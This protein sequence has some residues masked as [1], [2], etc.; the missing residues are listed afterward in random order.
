MLNNVA[1]GTSYLP[2]E[3]IINFGPDV[4]LIKSEAVYDLD[5]QV[6]GV[7][8]ALGSARDKAGEVVY[9]AK[10]RAGE[11]AENIGHAARDKQIEF[12][13]GKTVSR[14][15]TDDSGNIIVSVGQVITRSLAERADQ[16][17][18]LGAL[19]AAAGGTMLSTAASRVQQTGENA[20][21]GKRAGRDVEADDGSIIVANGQR[22]REE[23]VE[24]ARSKG[25]LPDLLA[26]AGLGQA[27]Q[28][29][30]G[31]G[32]AFS[33]TG[34][35]AGQ[36][37][38]EAGDTAGDLWD[39]FTRKISQMT[40]SAGKRV[41]EEK[42]KKRLSDIQDAVGRPV[43]KVILDKQDNVVLNLGDIITHE[44][45]Q[46]AYEAGMLDTLL[47]NVYKGDVQFSKEE[48]R[49]TTEGEATIEKSSG[50]AAV[51]QELEQ[52][53]EQAQQEREMESQHKRQEADQKRE[54]RS[55][56]REAL[57]IEREEQASDSGGSSKASGGKKT[58][59]TLAKA[60]TETHTQAI[61]S[62]DQFESGG[63]RS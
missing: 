14:S 6:G 11:A 26:A 58:S 57:K 27:Q 53:V 59:G 45:V 29:G 33:E 39:N 25:K 34:D 7:Q 23:Q 40:D 16:Q 20:A 44:S 56:E 55:E 63:K 8:G 12:L 28:A 10:E 38:G 60:S 19:V 48:M 36:V 18:K 62:D 47:D 35:R 32:S 5:A 42:T 4:I 50:D 54:Q 61:I 52:K 24:L 3:D 43:S 9:T 41:D 2:I 15:V 1:K 51:V 49:A 37:A 13:E 31:V 22:I 17:G 21:V 46:K 30:S